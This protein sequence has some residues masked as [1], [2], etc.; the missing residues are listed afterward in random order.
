M[1]GLL[2]WGG[3]TEFQKTELGQNKTLIENNEEYEA[4]FRFDHDSKQFR[5]IRSEER[6][7]LVCQNII[8][9]D[10]NDD[11]DNSNGKCKHHN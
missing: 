10:E 1:N 9:Q 8:E 2:I 4:P 7:D 11:C 6:Y 5:D 3:E